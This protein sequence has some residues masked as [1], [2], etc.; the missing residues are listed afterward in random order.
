M[1]PEGILPT[2]VTPPSKNAKSVISDSASKLDLDSITSKDV[3]PVEGSPASD[4]A[5]SMVP[6]AVETSIKSAAPPE[7]AGVVK[8]EGS[9]PLDDTTAGPSS[10]MSDTVINFVASTHD[11]AGDDNINSAR[12]PERAVE[13]TKK[14]PDTE[15]STSESESEEQSDS[16]KV[17][18]KGFKNNI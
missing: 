10:S 4:L 5:A 18:E 1:K 14:Q 3:E 11:T 13:K 17:S 8:A 2:I 16:Q 6:A 7:T 9:K 15:I 12:M